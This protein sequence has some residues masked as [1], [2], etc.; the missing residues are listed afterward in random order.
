MI[1]SER[2][3]RLRLARA[4]LAPKKAVAL[5][6]RFGTARDI[7]AAS[8]RQW[9]EV[10]GIQEKHCDRLLSQREASVEKDLDRLD[11]LEVEIL[12]LR[13]PLYPERL[14]TIYDPPVLLFV[15]GQ[16]DRADFPAIAVVGTRRA[17]S[18]GRQI[19]EWFARDLAGYGLT[20][21]SGAARGVD[22][23]AHRGALRSSGK[24]IA[25]LGCGIDVCY[26]RENRDLLEE[27]AASGAVISEYPP[28]T[29]PDSWRFP[30]RNRIISGLSMG[31]VVIE[32]P[33][34]SGALITVDFALE[35][36]REIFAVP[37]NIDSGRSRGCHRLIKEGA[38]LVENPKEILQGLGLYVEEVPS[39]RQMAM[40]LDLPEEDIALLNL[41]SL[42][43]KLLDQ[44]LE[45]IGLPSARVLSRLT[46]LELKGH[47]KRLP[48]NQFV[49][50]G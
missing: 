17:T 35:Q 10:E 48:G 3:A 28:G 45:E 7:W 38:H 32:A 8:S 12:S 20:V 14:R 23:A 25:V 36:G 13:D 2:E 49:R 31:V 4:E 16:W 11:R 22:T 46:F 26:P 33:E 21:V 24:T 5:L 1:L 44:I 34:D 42:Q 30:A 41:L 27:I 29:E 47:I 40:P 15:R 43:P 18:Y 6:E 9:E 37:G 19:S 50:V 39:P